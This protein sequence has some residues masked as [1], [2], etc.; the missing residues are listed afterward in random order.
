MTLDGGGVELG[1]G[2]MPPGDIADGMD[3]AGMVCDATAGDADA[4]ADD[5]DFGGLFVPGSGE[6]TCS[7]KSVRESRL[8]TSTLSTHL[9]TSAR[10]RALCGAMR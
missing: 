3:D 6:L 10:S 4:D 5:G 2:A 9:V 7:M 8:A 1:D